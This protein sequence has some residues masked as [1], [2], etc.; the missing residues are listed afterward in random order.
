MGIIKKIIKS[1]KYPVGS[2]S[3]INSNLTRDQS[4]VE[5]TL[6]VGFLVHIRLA[7]MFTQGTT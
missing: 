2:F 6:K 3:S 7:S 4:G 1:M 5:G